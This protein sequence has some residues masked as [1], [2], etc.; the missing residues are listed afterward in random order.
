MDSK[1]LAMLTDFYELT[2]M[3]G[4]VKNSIS[5]DIAVFDV[6][7]R[8]QNESTYCIACGLEQVV[9]YIENLVFTNSDIEYLKSLECFDN[10]FLLALRKFKFSGSIRAV[11]EGTVVFP[12]EPLLIVKGKIFE[13]QL[14]ESALLNIINFQTLIATKASRDRKSVV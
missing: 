2:M 13:A 3:N 7:F 5:E 4:F 1:K 6:F 8:E 12:N 9:D 11:P 10:K 14:L